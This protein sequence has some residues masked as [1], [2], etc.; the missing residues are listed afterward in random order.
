M[1]RRNF[2]LSS[3]AML[4]AS[5]LHAA[6]ETK[7]T[8]C[9]VYLGSSPFRQLEAENAE[10]FA[11]RLMKRGVTEAWAGAFE[12]LLRRDVAE[13][14]RQ[15][16]Q[17][18]RDHSIL[19]PCGTINLA[20]PAWQDD[21]KRCTEDHGMRVIRLHPNYHGYAL[22]APAFRELL[23][24]ATKHRLLIQL[25]AQMEDER[26]QHPQVRVAPVDLKPL[27]GIMKEM[28]EARVML[29]NANAAMVLKHLQDCPN[30]WL[31]FAMIEGVGSVE[32]LLKSWPLERLVFGSFAPVFY[33]ESAKLKMQES[34]LDEEQ[35]NALQAGNASVLCA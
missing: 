17:H 5:S 12:G 18:C 13:V 6:E 15:I 19:R 22:E 21:V 26:T 1:N 2:L 7:L 23:D 33:W 27:P 9:H 34:A 11:Q 20:L 16:V 10:E 3:S 30:V 31:D 35:R 32:N 14:N 24:L 28:P 29:L 8:D 25:V 4:A